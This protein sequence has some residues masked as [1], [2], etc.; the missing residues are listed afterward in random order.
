[1]SQYPEPIR[2][3]IEQACKTAQAELDSSIKLRD[4]AKARLESTEIGVNRAR[5]H[6]AALLECKQGQYVGGGC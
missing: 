1:M 3:L 5:A 4:D 6:L 2:K